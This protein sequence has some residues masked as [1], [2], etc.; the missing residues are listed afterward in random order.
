[1]L[2]GVSRQVC[3][4]GTLRYGAYS[5]CFRFASSKG[6]TEREIAEEKEEKGRD[7]GGDGEHWLN[8][9]FPNAEEWLLKQSE[10]WWHKGLSALCKDHHSLALYH[11]EILEGVSSEYAQLYEKQKHRISDSRSRTHL[12]QALLALATYR[13]VLPWL[14]FDRDQAKQLVEKLQGKESQTVLNPLQ[15][16]A[17]W[18]STNKFGMLA[19]RLKLLKMDYGDAFDIDYSELQEEGEKEK[20]SKLRMRSCFYHRLFTEEGAPELTQSC[21]CS[22][23]MIWFQG[24]EEKARGVTFHRASSIA[25]G[26]S[27]CELIVRKE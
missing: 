13:N 18:L 1:M 7:R 11:S 16:M 9:R 6:E 2:F 19:N 26:D 27:M 4:L 15:R 17:F 25:E 8:R 3:K 23:D 10:E 24:I 12:Q 22:V 14:Q 5:Q 20:E 21:C